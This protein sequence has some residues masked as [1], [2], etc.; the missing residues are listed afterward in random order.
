MSTDA[1]TGKPLQTLTGHTGHLGRRGLQVEVGPR[2]AVKAAGA[3]ARAL[4]A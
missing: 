3:I 2:D 1:A 4:V